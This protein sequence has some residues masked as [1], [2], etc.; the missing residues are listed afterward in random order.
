MAQ[1][2]NF[3]IKDGSATP[4]D[5]LF[6]CVQPAGGS[7]PAVYYARA[8]GLSAATQPKIQVSSKGGAKKRESFSTY[9]VPFSILGPDGVTRVVDNAYAEVRCVMP[10]S[11][12]NDVR[13]HLRAY[14]ANSLD[15]AQ[16][17]ETVETGYAPN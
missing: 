8:K 17:Q 9:L 15:V 2:A 11:V 1:A 12:P 4:A 5:T 14:L 13:A 10:D 3:T 7:L 6:T 16:F